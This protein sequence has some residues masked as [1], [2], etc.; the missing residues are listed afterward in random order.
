MNKLVFKLF[1]SQ[2]TLVLLI[3]L[4]TIFLSSCIPQ[5]T[6]KVLKEIPKETSK[7]PEVY[8]CPKE[9]CSKVL[10]NL[11][12][13]AN[14]SVHCAFYDIN[15]K[16]VI[17]ALAKKSKTI[18]AKL[19]MDSSNYNK[20]VMGDA[21]RLDNNQQLMHNKFC[22]I[23]RNIV[24]TGS[25]NPTDNDNYHNNNNIVVVYSHALASN[26]EEEFDELWSGKFSQGNRVRYPLIYVN[27]LKIE[28]YF[29][30]EDNCALHLVDQIK[31][32][33]NSIYFMTFSFTNEEI[34]DSLIRSKVPDIRGIFDS[35]QASN[36]YSQLKRLQEFGLNVKKDTNKYK[37]HHKVFI[38]DN[39]TIA[40]GSF[41]PTLSGDSNN[42]ENLII[43]H[44]KNITDD[45]LAEFESLWQ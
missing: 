39:E 3:F 31:N 4:S 23:D 38:F 21:I 41:N 17:S 45:F 32:A 22:V 18:D 35:S 1:Y 13:S 8:F 7:Y 11:I 30:P 20:Q 37:M 16:N 5:I 29:C 14:L 33:K 6:G 26:Y 10:E 34:S 28:N 12:I 40:T 9:D 24:T 36:K 44:D 15:L 42:D 27:D 2:I 43:I 25:F 19:V